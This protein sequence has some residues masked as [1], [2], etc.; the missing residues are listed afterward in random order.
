MEQM[1]RQFLWAKIGVGVMAALWLGFVISGTV[2]RYLLNWSSTFDFGIFSQMYYYMK[3]TGLPLTTCERDMLL[4]HFAVHMSP[5][6]YLLLPVYWLFPNP[7]TLFVMQAAVIILGV[8]PCYLIARDK[9]LP[10]LAVLAFC[11]VYCLYPSL[12]GGAFYDFHENA[13]LTGFIL[14]AL[15]FMQK[16]RFLWMYLFLLL[17][18]LVKEDA[19]VYVACIGLFLLFHEREYK[20][21]AAAFT[22][23]VIYFVCVFL[24]MKNHGNGVMIGRYDNIMPDEDLGLIG[25]FKVIL[26]NPAYL[27][28]EMFNMPEKVEF[29]FQMMIPLAFLPFFTIKVW[30]YILMIPFVL[31]NLLPDYQYQHSIY[32]QYTFGASAMLFYMAILNYAE[33]RA[34][35]GERKRKEKSLAWTRWLSAGILGLAVCLALGVNLSTVSSKGDYVRRYARDREAVGQVN[36][37][38]DSIPKEASVQ[39]ST[40]YVPR[41]SMRDVV[42]RIEGDKLLKFDTDYAVI[43]LRPGVEDEPQQQ[44]QAYEEAGYEL[45]EYME[46]KIAVLKKG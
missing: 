46:D 26:V 1:K 38:L 22:G 36:E 40:F 3:E 30:R 44:V 13:M 4:S 21:G 23:A 7:I 10:P 27:L 8:V 43:D 6:Y 18:A 45:T 25:I 17:T 34:W 5:A 2:C 11:A 33:L 29:F 24:W 37:I 19:P 9:G 39:A 35:L 15:Y 42:Y 41:I 14:W 31:W 16:K 20:H 32:F 28:Q 12:I